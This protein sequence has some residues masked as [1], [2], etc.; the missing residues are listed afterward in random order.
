MLAEL[1][2]LGSLIR[3]QIASLA[4][5][6]PCTRRSGQWRGKS[7]IESG[8]ASVR[9]ALYMAAATASRCNSPLA[10]FSPAVAGGG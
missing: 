5:L 8:R 7:F 9:T 10:V 3:R 6:A 1:P 2:E 4:G